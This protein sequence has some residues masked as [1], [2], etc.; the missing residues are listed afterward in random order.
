MIDPR[1]PLVGATIP[2]L[3]RTEV[4]LSLWTELTKTSPSNLSIVGPRGVGKTVLVNA[5]VQRTLTEES[6]YEFVLH[7][8]LGHVSPTS[9]SDFILELC[10][11]LRDS[12]AKSKRDTL[13]YRNYLQ[14]CS[15]ADL[16]EVTDALDSEGRFILM[17]WD[18]FDKPLRQGK[19]TGHLWDQM[20]TIFHGKRHKVVTATRALLSELI[21]SED[22]ITSPFWNIFNMTPFRVYAFDD[23]DCEMAVK[24]LST[25]FFQA[26]AKTELA[27]WSAG[28]PQLYLGILNQIVSDIPTG[29]V[30][31]SSV[32]KAAEK[33]VEGLSPFIQEMWKDCPE[34]SKDL[35]IYLMGSNNILLKDVGKNES[36]Y[37]IDSSFARQAGNKIIASCRML[38][39]FIQSSKPD[40]GTMARLFGTW[41]DYKNNIRGLLQRRLSQI[42][43]FDERLYR[44]VKRSIEDIPNY[45]DDC[46]NNLTNIEELALDLIWKRE[47]GA[48][49]SVPQEICDYWQQVGPTDK[50]VQCFIGQ[51]IVPVDRGLQCGILQN[52]TGCRRNFER[53]AKCITKDTYVL[54]SAIHSFRNRTQHPEGQSI[55]VGVAVAAIMLCLELLAC[56]D[57]ELRV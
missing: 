49:K 43:E 6:P 37:L 10:R 35:Y 1:F 2:L 36:S 12:L 45:P 21:R 34:S 4:M 14:S 23:D 24:E 52:L 31:N 17:L 8:H 19:L 5:L 32:N 38:E 57:R 54:V 13:D 55:D 28:V 50:G 16:K 11:R 46:L 41:E 9:D 33:A 47:F 18:G 27:N 15:F 30:D 22:A 25:H 48:A 7:W 20:R 39:K 44:L 3:G 29:S 42:N 26:G 56:L 40:I 53:K 51:N